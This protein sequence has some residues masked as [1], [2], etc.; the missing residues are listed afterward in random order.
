MWLS[1]SLVNQVEWDI[2]KERL[3]AA[4]EYF[5]SVEGAEKTEHKILAAL[6]ES[7][8]EKQVDGVD[9]NYCRFFELCG[10][11]SNFTCRMFCLRFTVGSIIRGWL[12]KKFTFLEY[13][14]GKRLKTYDNKRHLQI[15]ILKTYEPL[16]CNDHEFESQLCHG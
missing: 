2:K 3:T 9:L 5:W 6:F 7:V 1:R 12:E 4:I 13:K 11:L 15:L 16:A 14:A 10:R 8:N